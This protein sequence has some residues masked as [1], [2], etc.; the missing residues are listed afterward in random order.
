MTYIGARA[1]MSMVRA[2]SP[3]RIV[4]PEQG[5]AHDAGIV[6]EQGQRTLGL[7]FRGGFRDRLPAGQVHPADDGARAECLDLAAVWAK[8]SAS[9]SQST[10]T[11]APSRAARRA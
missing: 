3:R 10:T 6:D 2:M 11:A 1:L 8:P 4:V 9:T 7:R 5:A